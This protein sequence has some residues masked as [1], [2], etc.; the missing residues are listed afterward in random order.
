MSSAATPQPGRVLLAAVGDVNDVRTWSGTPFHL[1]QVA[2]A[3]RVIDAGLVVQPLERGRQLRRYA[4]N[5][6]AVLRGR[7]QGGYQYSVP[8]LE[9]LW[10]PLRGSLQGA[11]VINCFQ[12]YP[13]SVVADAR[14]E[15]WFYIDQ[16][17]PHLFG[18]YGLGENISAWMQRDAIAREREG[19]QS[20]AG[21][22]T[23]SRWAAESVI[24]EYGID[25]HKVHVVVPGANIDVDA[26]RLWAQDRA[27]PTMDASQPLRLVFVGKDALRKGLDRL[28]RALILARAEGADCRLRIIG[29]TPQRLPPTL[30][31]VEGVEWLGFID[32]QHQPQA[33]LDAVA[34][35][36]VGCLLSRAEAGGMCLREFHALG[37]AVIGPDVGGSPDHVIAEAAQLL[38]P[39]AT[40][41]Q[42]AALLL[43]L[44]RDRAEVQRLRAVSWARRQEAGWPHAVSAMAAVLDRP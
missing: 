37:L 16:T 23:H 8:C 5:L 11:R 28:I 34:G 19:Y 10:R 3:R 36:D 30:R 27:A 13:P 1:L 22:V 2:R 12:L 18:D 21:I 31:N 29:C 26:Y 15:K 17:L 39:E 14:I 40:D 42:I 24:R 43:R 32:K 44:S 6:A 25:A 35:N 9:Q 33:Y 20:A 41:M 7:G 4:W 38:A